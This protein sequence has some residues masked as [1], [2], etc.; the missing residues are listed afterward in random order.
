MVFTD[1]PLVHGADVLTLRAGGR[2]AVDLQRSVESASIEGRGELESQATLC[3]GKSSTTVRWRCALVDWSI[4]VSMNRAVEKLLGLAAHCLCADTIMAN[5]EM[6]QPSPIDSF[7]TNASAG[8]LARSLHLATK[9]LTSINQWG[10]TIHRDLAPNALWP[11]KEGINL[12]PSG[13]RC[14][15]IRSLPGTEISFGCSSRVRRFSTKREDLLP[16]DRC[17]RRNQQTNRGT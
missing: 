13:D 3:R 9:R 8:P 1:E 5:L 4:A 11:E 6:P 14:W 12:L 10:I 7:E 2:A 15:R 16:F 17:A